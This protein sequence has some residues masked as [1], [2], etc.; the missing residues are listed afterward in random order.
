M[1]FS[2]FF[3]S[4]VPMKKQK[5]YD[6]TTEVATA[7]SVIGWFGLLFILALLLT[8][9][10][11]VSTTKSNDP[12]SKDIITLKNLNEYIVYDLQ[13]GKMPEKTARFYVYSNQ[14]LMKKLQ[15]VASVTYKQHQ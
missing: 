14:I 11:N 5:Q 10:G 4:H 12:F 15:K 8:S 13:N 3:F 7:G 1:A 2:H 6:I 9:C